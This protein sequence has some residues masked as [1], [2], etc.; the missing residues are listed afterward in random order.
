MEMDLQVIVPVDLGSGDHQHLARKAVDE[1]ASQSGRPSTSSPAEKPKEAK[2]NPSP[3]ADKRANIYVIQ[4]SDDPTPNDSSETTTPSPLSDRSVRQAFVAKVF[5]LLS[6]QLLI[7]AIIIGTF[8]FCPA[9]FVIFIALACCGNIRREVPANYILLGLFTVLE[10][11]LLGTV[12]VFYSAEEVLWATA[13][14][15][16]VTL[17]ITLFALQTKVRI[18]EGISAV[19]V[20]CLC[21]SVPPDP[22]AHP[23][24]LCTTTLYLWHFVGL[25]QWEPQPEMRT[26]GERV[27]FSWLPPPQAPLQ[28]DVLLR[29][30]HCLTQSSGLP[31]LFL[32][33]SLGSLMRFPWRHFCRWF[34]YKHT[35]PKPHNLSVLRT[36]LMGGAQVPESC[37]VHPAKRHQ[38]CP[39]STS[40]ELGAVTV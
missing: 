7:T 5:L 24:G 10:G 37:T 8:V 13:T 9:F 15:T 28:L 18:T 25:G 1:G 36:R 12:S 23:A 35:L 27:L 11:L 19:R 6:A 22:F 29:R 2:G 21:P 14:T 3:K 39:G 34:P 20:C 33:A 32:P 31:V 17:A 38:V 26:G 4:I 16:L 30:I 40:E